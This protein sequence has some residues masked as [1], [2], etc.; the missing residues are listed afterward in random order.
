MSKDKHINDRVADSIVIK[1]QL[2]KLG[3]TLDQP[4]S[5]LITKH[6]NLYIKHGISQ[7]FQIKIN[8]N[9]TVKVTL[10][11]IENMKSGITLEKRHM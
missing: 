11:S 3:A 5:M 1:T 6:M 9:N 10:S 7:Q 4:S 2:Q 8:A